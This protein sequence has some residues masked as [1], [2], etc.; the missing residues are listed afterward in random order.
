M[1][2]QRIKARHRFEARSNRNILKRWNNHTF[3][4]P[5]MYGDHPARSLGRKK[6]G[7]H[8]SPNRSAT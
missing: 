1:N 2:T 4:G 3:R 5:W 8:V 6:G 7:S